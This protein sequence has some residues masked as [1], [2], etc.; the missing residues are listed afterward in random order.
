[1][2]MLSPYPQFLEMSSVLATY[3]FRQ[4]LSSGKHWKA[5]IWKF[6]GNL[7]GKA[8]LRL[9][10]FIQLVISRALGV[11][12]VMFIRSNNLHCNG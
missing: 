5:K 2:F 3:R 7:L 9:V 11:G 6:L 12:H 10:A 8:D 4:T 1:M